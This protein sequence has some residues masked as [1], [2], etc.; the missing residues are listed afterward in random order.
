MAM[1]IITD[2]RLQLVFEAGQDE[3]G[4]IITKKKSFN[5]V[6]TDATADQLYSVSQSLAS[7]QAYPLLN[8][9]RND[10]FEVNEG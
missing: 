2:S 7:L 9:V 8:V 1:Q 10:S 5:R 4:E 3:D 6:K